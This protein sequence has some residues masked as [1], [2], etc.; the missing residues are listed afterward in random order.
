MLLGIGANRIGGTGNISSC[1][2]FKKPDSK[3]R[4]NG[5]ITAKLTLNCV[6]GRGMLPTALGEV[7]PVRGFKWGRCLLHAVAGRLSI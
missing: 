4:M 5:V 3:R 2:L 6:E 7:L 1:S